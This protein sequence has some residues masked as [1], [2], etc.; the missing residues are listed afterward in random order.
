MEFGLNRFIITDVS[1]DT[2]ESGPDITFYTEV[3]EAFPEAEISASGHIHT[4][5]HLDALK[6]IGIKEVVV[7][8]KI[9][10]E[11]GLM[12]KISAFNSREEKEK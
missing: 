7:G 9:Y 5:D 11:E 8:E 12:D 10:Q 2:P 1:T 3:M 6:A 4:F